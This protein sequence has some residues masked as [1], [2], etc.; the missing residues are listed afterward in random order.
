MKISNE[1]IYIGGNGK[2]ATYLKNSYKIQST[3]RNKQDEFYFDLNNYEQSL[4]YEKLEDCT[5]VFGAAISSPDYCEDNPEECIKTNFLNTKN[6]IKKLL[7]KNKIIFLSSDLVYSGNDQNKP[8][9]E[10]I[11]PIP[12]N[13]YGNLKLKIEDEFKNHPSFH[14]LRL[15]FVEFDNN[16]FFE[17][18]NYC[19]SNEKKAEIVHPFIRHTTNPKIIYSTILNYHEKKINFPIINLSGEKK[20]RLQL[21]K[22]WELIFDKE[23]D[24]E[25]IAI[26]KSKLHHKPKYINFNSILTQ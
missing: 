10:S 25:V 5:I 13:L 12:N 9:D 20:S 11:R 24:F 18:L 7:T 23:I 22:T 8:L 21:L 26:E 4:L 17:Y 2:L 14:V 1:I 16:S 19:Y 3:S 15:S 6:A